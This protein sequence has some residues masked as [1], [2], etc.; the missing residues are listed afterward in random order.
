[1]S[2]LREIRYK[3]QSCPDYD[4]CSGCKQKG[5]H[6]EHELAKRRSNPKGICNKFIHH[7]FRWNYYYIEK[8]S[9]TYLIYFPESSTSPSFSPS[10]D[11]ALKNFEFEYSINNRSI[12][13]SAD[14][15]CESYNPGWVELDNTP[16]VPSV[17]SQISRDFWNLQPDSIISSTYLHIYKISTSTN[18]RFIPSFPWMRGQD[19]SALSM[20]V[21]NVVCSYSLQIRFLKGNFPDS[22][23]ISP[24]LLMN[25]K[26]WT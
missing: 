25:L 3:C 8:E 19:A 10:F 6:P 5:I 18:W 20:I 1:M 23:Y 26:L 11:D 9:N 21:L 14:E 24:S 15:T 2:P 22:M 12:R 16:A 17:A 4:L 13:N 7:Y